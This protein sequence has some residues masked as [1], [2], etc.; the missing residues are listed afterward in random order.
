MVT[1]G[2]FQSQVWPVL[3]HKAKYILFRNFKP[4]CDFIVFCALYTFHYVEQSELYLCLPFFPALVYVNKKSI[5]L[6]HCLH[7]ML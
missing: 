1:K 7:L 4:L 6:F 2:F 3:M 5:Y